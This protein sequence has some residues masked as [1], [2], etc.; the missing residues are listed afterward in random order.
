[1]EFQSSKKYLHLFYTVALHPHLPS[2]VFIF[3]EEILETL[4]DD[5]NV[6]VSK[7]AIPWNECATWGPF[8]VKHVR[9]NV[10]VECPKDMQPGTI[11]SNIKLKLHFSS[12][13][14]SYSS[15]PIVR[16]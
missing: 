16:D 3:Q 7:Q 1:V 9:L 2:S 12:E 14:I 5:F 8:K 13:Y 6:I 10:I 4:R 15:W 11:I